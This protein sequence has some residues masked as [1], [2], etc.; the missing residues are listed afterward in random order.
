MNNSGVTGPQ[1]GVTQ[2]QVSRSRVRPKAQVN[3]ALSAKSW[4]S[5]MLRYS[6]ESTVAPA[7]TPAAGLVA[8][9]FASRVAIATRASRYSRLDR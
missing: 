9:E 3:A 5:L 8:A 4:A 7:G 2:I 1:P 6:R